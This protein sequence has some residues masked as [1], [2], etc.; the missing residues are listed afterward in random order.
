MIKN[1]LVVEDNEVHMA[2]LEKL[3]LKI[4]N[5]NIFKAY[6]MA[7]A[8]YMLSLREYHL[9]IVDIILDTKKP[10][11]VSGMDFVSLVR[12]NKRYSFTPVIFTTS[13]EDPKLHA[14]SDLHCYQ[15]IE[16]PFDEKY[17]KSIVVQALSF[18]SIKPMKEYAYFR[19][20]GILYAVRINEIVYITLGKPGVCM[21][22]ENDCLK[23]GYYTATDLQRQLQSNDFVRCNRNII[24]NKSYIEYADFANGY[25]K[26]KNIDKMF[27]MGA[28]CKKKLRE[29][30]KNAE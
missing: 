4:P 27:E 18:P 1:V 5:L 28:I 23:L 14:Y 29:E 3:L 12:D 26:L 2:A 6:N 15:Y 8:C 16:K 25:I 11:D 20:D 13:L 24:I 30:F 22:M 9:F 21:Y 10:G 7:E 19:K 17:V